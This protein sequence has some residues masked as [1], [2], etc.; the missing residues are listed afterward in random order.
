L[1]N[2]KTLHRREADVENAE[3]DPVLQD[4]TACKLE[5]SRERKKER[6]REGGEKTNDDAVGERDI[7]N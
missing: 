5:E 3:S 6:G 1:A 2:G 7:M 4:E